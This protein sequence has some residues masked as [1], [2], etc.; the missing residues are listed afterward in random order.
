MKMVLIEYYGDSTVWGTVPGK[1]GQQYPNP[2]PTVLQQELSRRCGFTV[3][4]DNKAVP[5]T[6]ASQLLYGTQEYGG[7][8]FQARM[9]ASTAQ[10]VIPG[11]FGMND[12]AGYADAPSFKFHLSELVRIAKETG[13]TVVL[14]T[15]NPAVPGGT[16]TLPDQPATLARFI[17]IVQEVASKYSVPMVDQYG[18]YLPVQTADF[19]DG[20]H[21]SEAVSRQKGMRVADAVAAAICAGH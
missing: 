8:S 1:P 17:P 10:V 2:P 7:I 13:K 3:V 14:E 16:Y 19:P 9:A 4:V 18:P 20:L 12:A 15:P 6:Y 11:G 21:P 5:G